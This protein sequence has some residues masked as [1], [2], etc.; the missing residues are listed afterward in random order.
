MSIEV[1]S[2]LV[3]Q[4]IQSPLELPA[5]NITKL[6]WV[7]RHQGIERNERAALLANKVTN[8]TFL[9]PKPVLGI[10][11][12]DSW[13]HYHGQEV[14]NKFL[15]KD[16]T[17][18]YPIPCLIWIGNYEHGHFRNH[19]QKV[20][21]FTGKLQ[22]RLCSLTIETAKHIFL[23]CEALEFYRRHIFVDSQPGSF[24]I[25]GIGNKIFNLA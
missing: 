9:G 23:E 11:W 5:A 2:E 3:W 6:N 4:C 10:C 18:S 20:G 14:G 17:R 1:S 7:P 21:L 12:L 22:C 19:L 8:K 16:L 24:D 13:L 15:S 25:P